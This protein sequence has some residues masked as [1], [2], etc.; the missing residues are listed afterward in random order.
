MSGSGPASGSHRSVGT[1]SPIAAKTAA[2][3]QQLRHLEQQHRDRAARL[4]AAGDLAHR[5]DEALDLVGDLG[6]EIAESRRT[7][8][9]P[10]AQT[11]IC[12]LPSNAR[13]SVTSSAY[14][15]SPPTGNPLA[16]LV[17]RNPIG[18]TNRAK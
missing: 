9:R 15:R 2:G 5:D 4:G 18:F 10:P 3:E 12:L 14:S 8:L 1:T 7:D 17:T 11:S 13:P 16:N 6:S